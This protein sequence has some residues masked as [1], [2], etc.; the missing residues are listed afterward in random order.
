MI[1]KNQNTPKF[2]EWIQAGINVSWGDIKCKKEVQDSLLDEQGYI[3]GYCGKRISQEEMVIEHFIPRTFLRNEISK[4]NYNNFV[5]S[6]KG[7]DSEFEYYNT[8]IYLSLDEFISEIIKKYNLTIEKLVKLN[9]NIDLKKLGSGNKIQVSDKKD[10]HCDRSKGDSLVLISPFHEICETI[11]LFDE[12]GKLS[13]H[14][15]SL[16]ELISENCINKKYIKNLLDQLDID[17]INFETELTKL[18]NDQLR[19]E[20]VTF[21]ERNLVQV[22]GLNSKVLIDQR[23]QVFEAIVSFFFMQSEEGFTEEF[24][25][26]EQIHLYK[27]RYKESI[28]GIEKEIFYEFSNECIQFIKSYY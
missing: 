4:L 9:P 10:F 21:L 23:K 19:D 18:S 11:F 26:E 12:N 22:L 17:R 14:K 2:I 20:D 3:C 24:L 8:R 28:N 16:P 15:E 27:S 7:G 13:I 25:K 1:Q 6:C 5:A